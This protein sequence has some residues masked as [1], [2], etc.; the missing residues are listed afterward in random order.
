MS[1]IVL[2]GNSFIKHFAEFLET[3]DKLNN[4]G[5]DESKFKIRC[6]GLM[7]LSL[8]RRRQLHSREKELKVLRKLY[9][10]LLV[11]KIAVH[12]AVGCD[13]YDG[14]FLCCPF[15]HEVSWTRS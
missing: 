13:D 7:G 8:S 14:V 6:I 15:S 12:L 4:L 1:D 11:W 2:F 10:K 3:D 9:G 5:L